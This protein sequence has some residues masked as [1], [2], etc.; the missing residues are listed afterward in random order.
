[1]PVIGMRTFG[2]GHAGLLTR[3]MD[4]VWHMVLP[5]ILGATGGIA[6]LSRYVR[7]QMLEVEGQDYV[8]TARAKGLPEEQVHYKHALRNALLPFVTMFGLVLPGLIGGSVIIESIFS[9]PGIGRMAYEAILARDYPVIITV[10]F[11]SAILV[12]LGTLLS[13]IL[14]MLADPRIKL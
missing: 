1:V 10:N 9:W 8:R 2:L 7:N 5:A 4:R 13:D 11:V 12:L 6:V 14:Y 3:F